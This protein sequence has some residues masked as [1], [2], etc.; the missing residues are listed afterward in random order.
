VPITFHF[1][2]PVAEPTTDDPLEDAPFLPVEPQPENTPNQPVPFAPQTP[3]PGV[4]AAVGEFVEPID[5]PTQPPTAEELPTEP[6]P[7]VEQ[8]A[9]IEELIANDQ[10]PPQ[11][12]PQ[13]EQTPQRTL[14]LDRAL[15][16][17]G[18]RLRER[19]VVPPPTPGADGTPSNVFNPQLDQLPA[20]GFG[21]GMLSFQSKDFDWSDYARQIHQAIWRAWH[22]RLY[23]SVDDFEKW[24]AQR[25]NRGLNHQAGLRFVIESNGD[26]SRISIE[27]E[28]GC[29]PFDRSAADALAAVILPPLPPEF[30]RDREIVDARFI[31]Q[32]TI[33]G[34]GS[35]PGMRTMLRYMRRAGYF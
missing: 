19:P 24:S 15:L 34:R 28:S 31:G 5:A 6:T 22:N 35:N 17:F 3:A 9:R 16:E 29:L 4:S 11:F 12:E 26:V 13:P 27:L 25:G 33:M 21:M 20:T 14:D 18:E 23:V 7:E 30:P 10:G 2:N 32:G 1:A 8:E